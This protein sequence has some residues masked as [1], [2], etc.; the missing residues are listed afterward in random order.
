MGRRIVSIKHITAPILII[1]I[2]YCNAKEENPV[3]RS[4]M[5]FIKNFQDLTDRSGHFFKTNGV[6]KPTQ[7]NFV[8]ALKNEE[9]K[10]KI[11][12]FA[13]R[14]YPIIHADVDDLMQ[15][16]LSKKK[17]SGTDDEK[18][19]YESMTVQSFT[20]RLLTKRPLVFF[21]PNDYWADK[22][23]NSG[24]GDWDKK[25]RQDKLRNFL[26]Y[27][28]IKISALIQLSTETFLINSG[29]RNN[30]GE[31]G[32]NGSFIPEAVYVA[33]VG[34]RF[35]KPGKM[36]YQDIVV[37]KDKKDEIFENY[38]KKKVPQQTFEPV[39]KHQ[40]D[41]SRYKR[42]MRISFETFLLEA[43]KRGIDQRRKVYCHVVGL[44]LGV[45]QF[46]GFNG[47]IHHWFSAF[48][49]SLDKLIKNRHVN[50][51]QDI[52]FSWV[53]PGHNRV[54]KD[55]RVFKESD[56]KIHVSRRDPFQT[57]ESKDE[58][59]LV[60]AMFAWDGNSY[61]GN[62][63]WDGMLTASGDPAAASCSFIP[64]LLNPD[65]NSAIG[66]DNLYVASPWHGILPYK[67]Y[68]EKSDKYKRSAGT[69]FNQKTTAKPQFNH[70]T[71]TPSNQQRSQHPVRQ[72]SQ[73]S[74][75]TKLTN[76][77]KNDYIPASYE[78][79]KAEESSNT[80]SP[81]AR[82][83]FSSGNSITRKGEQMTNDNKQ[84][85][86]LSSVGDGAVETDDKACMKTTASKSQSDAK[87]EE[88][89]NTPEKSS[90]SSVRL[91]ND[92]KEVNRNKCPDDET[93]V[94]EQL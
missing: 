67:E 70:Q 34:A 20:H 83:R 3:N 94:S 28:E 18:K 47:Q 46:P 16:F 91:Q 39:G 79:K 75:N 13:N 85:R 41:V 11:V 27:D 89:S 62:E 54:F 24:Q 12:E 32:G 15:K 44:G 21:N 5:S 74:N 63:Y 69:D 23:G 29:S 76:G 26:S 71:S 43:N 64:E 86:N 77:N 59:K 50:N 68:V 90:D 25:A 19:I 56:I 49:E 17:I 22:K 66:G 65:I 45:W 36:D 14:A 9:E 53:D 73:D 93:R 60:V 55:G 30:K 48:E 42:R 82:D 4:R 2:Y 57:V 72:L 78:T 61:V 7:N 31:K 1:T 88:S 10:K 87:D 58:A 6:R 81:A 52:N 33:A 37:S 35:E 84:E 40:L 8:A 51:I 80:S 38:Y 92:K